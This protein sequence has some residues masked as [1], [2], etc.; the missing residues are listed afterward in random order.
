MKRV[1]LLL[2]LMSFAQAVFA[3]KY[4]P[5]CNYR[6]ESSAYECPKCLRL[7][8][9]PYLPSRETSA[10]LTVR[11]GKDAFIRHPASQIRQFKAGRNTGADLTGQIGSWGHLTGLRYLIR[12]DVPAAMQAAKINIADFKLRRARLKLVIADEN[13]DQQIP[14][15]VFPLSQPF[16]AGT[17]LY[18][19]RAKQ[20]DG[21]TWFLR[22][23]ML[24]WQRE[25][26][27]FDSEVSGAGILGYRGARELV[28]DV[29]PIFQRRFSELQRTGTWND[30]GMIIMRDAERAEEC[31]FLSIYSLESRVKGGKVVAPQLLLD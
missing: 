19:I 17:G 9:W 3:V 2:L 15:R 5:A 4:C 10:R 21:T 18:R 14:L 22:A 29:T 30:P 28:I 16:V 7:I 25:G 31:T 24:D 23:P 27:D 11:T 1:C 8:A 6:L 26:G 12:F 20:P 13:I